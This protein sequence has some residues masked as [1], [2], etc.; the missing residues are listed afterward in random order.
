MTGCYS[1]FRAGKPEYARRGREAGKMLDVFK[2]YLNWSYIM[3]LNNAGDFNLACEEGHATDLINVAEALQEK[4][5]AQIAD[6]IF[7]RG[8]NGNRVKL[9]LIAGP[10]SS[11]KTTFSK[12]LSIQLMTNGLK[13]SRSLWIIIS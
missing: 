8:E 4:K 12:R 6:T 13:H 7:H 2:E 10:S 11:G 1:G 3:G 9:V 5:I